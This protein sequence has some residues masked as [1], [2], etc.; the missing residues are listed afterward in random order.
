MRQVHKAGDKLF[1]DYSEAVFGFSKAAVANQES[2]SPVA[3]NR[4][5]L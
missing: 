3:S 1:V 5:L 4:R 2:V